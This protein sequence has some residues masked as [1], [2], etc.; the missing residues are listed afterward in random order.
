MGMYSFEIMPVPTLASTFE[1]GISVTASS[2][3]SITTNEVFQFTL[4]DTFTNVTLTV[5]ENTKASYEN[6]IVTWK[7][8]S[9]DTTKGTPL[10][11][12]VNAEHPTAL[13]EGTLIASAITNTFLNE[14][15]EEMIEN[16]DDF[17]FTNPSFELKVSVQPVENC[18]YQLI[19]TA[20]N[21]SNATINNILINYQLNTTDFVWVTPPAS[22]TQWNVGTLTTNAPGKSKTQSATIR[23]IGTTTGL[24]TIFANITASPAEAFTG[25]RSLSTTVNNI[26]VSPP[27]CEKCPVPVPVDFVSCEQSETATVTAEIDSD[28][29]EIK[30]KVQLTN[31]CKNKTVVVGLELFEG[32]ITDPNPVRKALK[33]IQLTRTTGD[34]GC[35]PFECD[36]LTFFIP[37]PM[38]SEQH[39][40][41]KAQAHYYNA[42][43]SNCSCTCAATPR[44]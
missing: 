31:V 32:M 24:K 13:E 3:G 8:G 11:L 21:T 25:I 43:P 16:Y 27:C 23:F 20:T 30:V 19:F 37:G 18:I 15:G 12:E 4:N 7:V 33:V 34:N 40:F 6:N 10:V 17:I 2:D 44:I 9:L 38:C 41:I 42:P 22:T 28:G 39:F 5:P 1:Y 35:A 29:R 36:C 14:Q 26:C